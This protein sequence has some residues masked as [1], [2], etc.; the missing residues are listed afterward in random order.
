MYLNIDILL[1][2]KENNGLKIGVKQYYLTSQDIM[3]YI[4]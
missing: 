1:N 3:N 2:K 4:L